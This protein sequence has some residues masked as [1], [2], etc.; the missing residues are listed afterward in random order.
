MGESFGL[1][2]LVALDIET[3]GLYPHLGD[4]ICEIAL[5]NI[6]NGEIIDRLVTLVNPEREISFSAYAVNGITGEMVQDSPP[7]REIA[8]SVRD[9][10]KDRTVL[11]HNANFDL[12][13]LKTQLHNCGLEFPETNL[14]DTLQI[15]RRFFSFP[16]NTLGNLAGTFKIERKESHRAE[17]D[18][19]TAYQ[20]LL[21]FLADLRKNN[22]K[23]EHLVAMT[24]RVDTILKPERILPSP[25]LRALGKNEKV[26]IRY[27]NGEGLV[28]T[29]EI[30]P[31]EVVSES[32]ALYLRA[33]CHLKSEQRTFR[34]DR[35]MEVLENIE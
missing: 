9:F 35:I 18:A 11:V 28:S 4:R 1:P 12:A 21:V 16:S 20:V 19:W 6:K 5:L 10:L 30:E 34:L 31:L 3:T 22:I 33:F 32:G 29:R 13:F 24:S 26:A 8:P 14:L 2:E 7:F 27:V 15:A 23:W 17:A 25:L